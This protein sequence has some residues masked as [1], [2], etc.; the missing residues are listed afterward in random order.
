M[1]PSPSN[2]KAYNPPS[3]GFQSVAT[4][5]ELEDSKKQRTNPPPR[6]HPHPTSTDPYTLPRTRPNRAD[7]EIR[8]PVWPEW[9][10]RIREAIDS[11]MR[12][13]RAHPPLVPVDKNRKRISKLNWQ[14]A[15]VI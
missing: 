15:E 2:Q 12:P 7:F 11:P 14:T 1:L 8:K 10:A 9:P 3:P 6:F 4:P 5:P 13:H